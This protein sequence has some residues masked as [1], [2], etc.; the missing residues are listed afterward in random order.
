M[1]TR[2]KATRKTGRPA[3]GGRQAKVLTPAEL[4]RVEKCLAGTRKGLRD[5]AMFT[6]QLATGMRAA[7]LASLNV[8]D[9]L[10]DRAIRHEF[11]LGTADAKYCR[12]RTIYLEHPKAI[13]ALLGYLRSRRSDLAFEGTERLFVGQK[14]NER[15]RSFRLCCWRREGA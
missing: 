14:Q 5:R 8:G 2:S 15:E 4:T 3:G 1:A 7:E 9:V 12:S 13:T 6:L 11:C 10:H